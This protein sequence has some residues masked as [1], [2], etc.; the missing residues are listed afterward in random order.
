MRFG[1]IPLGEAEGA[2]IVHSL[3]VDGLLFKKGRKLSRAD[4]ERLIV[5]GVERVPAAR[6]EANDVPEDLA[7]TRIGRALTGTGLRLGAA[8]TG[9]ANL[10]AEKSGLVVL[11]PASVDRI[12]LIDESLTLATLA[13]Y[14]MVT[15]GEMVAT[16]KIIPYAAPDSAVR[17]A[18]EAARGNPIRVAPFEPMRV[19]L[20][21]T[22]LPGQKP[23]LLDKNRSALETR[24]RPLGGTLVLEKRVPHETGAVTTALAEAQ[25]TKAD[26]LLVFGAS[27]ITDRRDVIP[28]GVAAAGGEIL[29]FGMPV[30]PGNLLLLAHL[31]GKPAIGLPSCARS[32]KVNGF[33]FVLQRLFARL[34]VTD[35]DIMR[36]GVGGLLQEIHS[37]PQPRDAERAVLRA[38]RIAAIVLAAG[39]SSRM[40]SNKLLQEWRGKPL[41]RWVAEAALKS[42]ARPVIVVTGNEQAKVEGALKGLD[43]KF[44]HNPDY[45]E[46]LSTS[47]RA[48][49]AGVPASADGALVLLGDMPEID[50][51]LI[52][53]MIAAFSPADGRSICVATCEHKRGNPVLWA[54]EFFPEIASLSGDM[55]A[56]PVLTA[57][58]DNVCEIEAGPAAL[59]DVDTPE[60]LQTLR[61]ETEAPV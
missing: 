41:L 1:T 26:L 39:L 15:P 25:E 51:A 42:E 32:P 10:Y 45:R 11:D 5:S 6:L 7:A 17:A 35:H 58:D 53:R 3:R 59:R 34:P 22:Q 47:L 54:K 19:A 44:V 46:G 20:I 16:V 13:P 36:M 24:L 55:G 61:T 33:D 23:S 8:F 9:R 56:K 38:P 18:T 37:R 4:I 40:G 12:N 49:I 57:N 43:V 48:G 2:I 60:A 21:S 29:H 14:A 50:A 30:D 31:Q 52:D 27:A 28:A